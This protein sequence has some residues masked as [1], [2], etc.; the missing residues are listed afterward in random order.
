[1]SL[2]SKL[3]DLSYKLSKITLW[4][5]CAQEESRI[6]TKEKSQKK[7]DDQAFTT[8]FKNFRN[9][10]KFFLR[11]ETDKASVAKESEPSKKA[12]QDKTN[13]FF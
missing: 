3:L 11:K 4:T 2:T 1:L 7:Y 5:C 6:S 12:K 8:K 10:R 13:F 9:T